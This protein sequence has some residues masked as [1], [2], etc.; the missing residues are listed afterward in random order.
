VYFISPKQINV[1][2]PTDGMPNSGPV[3]VT[4][5]NAGGTSDPVSANVAQFIPGFFLFPE[6]YV[7]AVRSDGAFIGK[8]GLFGTTLTTTPAKPGDV[9]LLFG[10]GFGPTNPAVEA[11]SVFNGAAPTANPVTMTI[12]G[13]NATVAFAGLSGAGLYQ[14]NVT[15]PN[16]PDGDQPVVAQ[17]GGVSTQSG[18]LITIRQ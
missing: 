16:V 4:V 15:V 18:A 17:V 8:T 2:A 6:R 10:T 3:Q 14:F 12:G 13:V 1:Q 7:A 9:V 5:S 11:G